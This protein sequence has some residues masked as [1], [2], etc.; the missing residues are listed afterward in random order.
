M[1]TRPALVADS[2]AAPAS[3]RKRA[4]GESRGTIR[5]AKEASQTVT[6][7]YDVAAIVRWAFFG[8]AALVFAAAFFVVAWRGGTNYPTTTGIQAIATAISG[9]DNRHPKK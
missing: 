4:A 3:Q 1:A 5:K 8:L 6:V 9:S 7:H 2:P